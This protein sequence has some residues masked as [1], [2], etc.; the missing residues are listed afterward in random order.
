[1]LQA[2]YSEAKNGGRFDRVLKNK[3]QGNMFKINITMKMSSNSVE[4]CIYL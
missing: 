1:M 3:M 2:T 4:L